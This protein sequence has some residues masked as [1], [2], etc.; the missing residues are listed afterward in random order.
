MTVVDDRTLAFPNY[1]GNGM[2]ITMGN[3]RKNPNVGLLFISFTHP[4]RMRLNG[5]A[6]IDPNDPPRAISERFVR[7]MPASDDILPPGD[8]RDWG[9]IEA[10][11]RKIVERAAALPRAGV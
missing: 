8:F 10:R 3:L 11:A 6:S 5:V 1:D 2:Y 7:L 9:A 4:N